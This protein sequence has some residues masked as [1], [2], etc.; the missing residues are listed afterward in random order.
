M[1]DTDSDTPYIVYQPKGT[2]AHT[3]KTHSQNHQQNYILEPKAKNVENIES[4]TQ[5][6]QLKELCPVW[7][8]SFSPQATTY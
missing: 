3:T 7:R 6:S 4:V 8:T 1:T 2:V 5:Q